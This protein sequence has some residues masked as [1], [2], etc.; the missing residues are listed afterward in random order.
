MNIETRFS[1][2]GPVERDFRPVVALPR[3]GASGLAIGLIAIFLAALL[4]VFLNGRRNEATRASKQP[5]IG[6][7]AAFAAPPPLL[8]P[9]LIQ[10]APQVLPGL[11]QTA[12]T[13]PSTRTT[14]TLPE[15]VRPTPS[16]APPSPMP[17]G[18][19]QPFPMSPFPAPVSA[20]PVP[21]AGLTEPAL[22]G[23]SGGE[24][25]LTTREGES[26]A[27]P[28]APPAATPSESRTP[29][30]ASKLSSKTN[31]VPTGTMIPAVLETPIDTSRPG[32]I[33]AIVSQ[34]TRGFDGH[35]VLIPRGSRLIGEFQGDVRSGQKRVLV[36]WAR[37]ILPDGVVIKLDS[38]A[39]DSLGG[40]GVPGQLHSFF[41]ARFLNSAVQSALYVGG[42][43]LGSRGTTVVVGL[44]TGSATGAAAQAL[45]PSTGPQPKITVKQGALLN[46]FVAHDLDFSSRSAGN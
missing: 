35:R 44:P 16:F 12:V 3:S 10:P 22:L 41:L 24:D 17:I 1:G 33:R 26:A 2:A 18:A 4:F 15:E 38:P 40:P 39:A 5:D 20:P 21:E 8:V 13:A 42:T 7:S 46:V 14:P 31:L 36:S 28:S 32:L 25:E 34:D 27:S 23:D 29:Y 30:R 37:L 9:P 6:D 11:P 43:L 45:T 19:G